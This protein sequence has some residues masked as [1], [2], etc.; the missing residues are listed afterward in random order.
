[1]YIAGATYH[2]MHGYDQFMGLYEYK[3]T[4]IKLETVPRQL[5]LQTA[6]AC[7]CVSSHYSAVTCRN[8]NS[9]L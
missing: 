1:M 7:F 4:N 9:S 2:V 8:Q 6:L 5:R 3:M